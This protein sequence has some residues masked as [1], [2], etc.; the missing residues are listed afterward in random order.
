AWLDPVELTPADS[1]DPSRI[2]STYLRFTSARLEPSVAEPGQ[3]VDIVATLSEPPDPQVFVV[4]AAR[5]NRTG[6]IY[7]LSPL[8]DGRYVAEI[9]VDRHFSRDDHVL[10]LLAYPQSEARAGRNAQTERTLEKDGFWDAR[11][12]YVYDPLLV[13]S[14]NRP[15]LILTVVSPSRRRGR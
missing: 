10:S 6:K 1:D 4:V 8:G 14:R 9:Q 15:D 12:P 7:E 5:D 3:T 11:K 2:R 13:A